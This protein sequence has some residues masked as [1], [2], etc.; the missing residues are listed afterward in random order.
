M[1]RNAIFVKGREQWVKEQVLQLLREKAEIPGFDT[2][3]CEYV[4]LD[5]ANGH[6]VPR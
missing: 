3:L 2:L 5:L 1:G 4:R 6:D